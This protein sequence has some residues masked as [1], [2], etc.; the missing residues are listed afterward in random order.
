MAG[1]SASPVRFLPVQ[2]T[3]RV[4]DLLLASWETDREQVGRTVPA[5]FEPTAVAGRFVVSL[6]AFRVHGGRL[7]RLPVLPYS[8]LNVRVYGKWQSEPAVFFLAAR[9]SA[10]G[11]PGVLLR[12]P[13]RHARLGVR[14]GNL[15]APGLGVSLRYE[16]EEPADAGVLGRHELGLFEADGLRAVRI[17]RGETT[18]RGAALSEPARADFLAALGFELR[19]EPELFYAERASFEATVPPR[20]V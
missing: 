4:C 5:G 20:M 8:Q 7:G 14:R 13:F 19:G 9:V 3:L 15:R 11:L 16:V 10:G 2:A 17:R 12:A 1:I 18:W 6:A